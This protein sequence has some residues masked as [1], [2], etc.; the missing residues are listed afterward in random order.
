M[1]LFKISFRNMKKSFSDYAIYFLTLML[2]VTIFYMFNSMDSQTA[3]LKMTDS[4]KEI[5][6]LLLTMLSMVSVFVA[7]ILGFLIIY[8]NNFLIKRRKKEFGLYMLLGMGKGSISAILIGE[9]FIAGI[10][11]L[12]TGLIFGIFGSQLMSIIVAK[13][14]EADMSEFT[15]V[16]SKSAAIQTIIYFAFMYIIVIIF[17]A[18]LISKVKLIDLLNAKKI[19]EKIRTKNSFISISVFL[20]SVFLLGYAYINVAWF[21]MDLNE[22][23]IILMI[24]IGCI[25][26]YLFF[27]S[28]SG[29][30]LQFLKVQKNFYHKNLN[31]FVTRQLNSQ[32]NTNVF[33]MTII[34]LLLFITICVLS[35]GNAINNSLKKSLREMTPRDVC[36]IQYAK[37]SN[38]QNQ[39][40]ENQKKTLREQLEEKDF[41]INTCFKEDIAIGDI[42]T[43]KELTWE[44]SF[45]ANKEEVKESFPNLLWDTKE[46]LISL[47][48]YNR[49][50]AAYGESTLELKENEFIMVCSFENMKKLRDNY[51][52]STVISIDGKK[53]KSAYTT[54][55]DG[56]IEMAGSRTNTGIYVLPDSAFVDLKNS[57]INLEKTIMTADY[58]GETKEEKQEIEERV[59]V[60][61]D[62]NIRVVSKISIYEASVGLGAIITF[63]AV[64]LGIIFLI[65][66]A[67]ILALKQLSDSADNKERYHI[68][69]KIGTDEK[70]IDKALYQQIGIFFFMPLLLA[71]VHSI[72]GIRFSN[73]F[74]S[75]MMD[76]F[77]IWTVVITAVFIAGIYGLYFFATY[78]ESKKMIEE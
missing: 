50:A 24:I 19:V 2:G 76:D 65:S 9:T 31:M 39:R 67:A 53:Y 47:S 62:E 63:I 38:S 75:G 35:C 70:M 5:I 20:L 17:N 71:I 48:D 69:R 55:L 59:A 7:I 42:Y 49:L 37:E 28:L 36:F 58:Y 43:T 45:E 4:K 25:A 68:L 73:N 74:L 72:F 21:T 41:D 14:F 6:E 34:C 51:L 46:E 10:V 3:L 32:I 11:S 15:F 57:S 26:T 77:N 29:F 40:K 1:M 13:M 30:L 66:G 60:L 16:F 22:D 64:Y 56:Y 78:F 23:K 8:A 54:C 61:E 12:L 27:W 44:N 18:I 33:S 52:E